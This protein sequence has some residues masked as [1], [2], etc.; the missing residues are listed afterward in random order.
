[1]GKRPNIDVAELCGLKEAENDQNQSGEEYDEEYDEEDDLEN[2]DEFI[3]KF[4]LE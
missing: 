3:D 1:L 4:N 2:Y